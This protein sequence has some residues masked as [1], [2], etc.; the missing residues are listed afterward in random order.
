MKRIPLSASQN[1]FWFYEQLYPNTAAN[2]LT[3]AC[4]LRNIDLTRFQKAVHDLRNRH[5]A[6]NCTLEAFNEQ[7]YLIPLPSPN[8]LS[9]DGR[10]LSIF[11]CSGLLEIPP[12]KDL[13]KTL[14]SIEQDQFITQGFSFGQGPLWRCA[15][16][17]FSENLFQFVMVV[18]HII[19]D[20]FSENILMRDL[21][22]LY[23]NEQADLPVLPALNTFDQLSQNLAPQ[24]KLDFWQKTLKDLTPLTLKTDFKPQTEFRHRGE[25]FYFEVS[26][27]LVQALSD[28]AT[29]QQSSLHRTF[30][31]SL[32]AL[33]YRYTGQTDLCIGTTSANRR[34]YIKNVDNVVSC[35]MNSIPLRLL[36]E[37]GKLSFTDLLQ[38]LNSI[39]IE[40][41]QNQL[42]FDVI[43]KQAMNKRDK[44]KTITAS[45]FDII[46]SLNKK[47]TSLTLQDAEASYP[48]ELTLG[49]SRFPLGLN[50]DEMPDGSYRAYLEYNPDFFKKSTIER[51]AGHLQNTWEAV[52]AGPQQILDDLSFLT[53]EER[54]LLTQ[55]HDTLQDDPPSDE[56]SVAQLFDRVVKENGQKPAVVFHLSATESESFTYTELDEKAKMLAAL[57]QAAGVGPEEVV[58][59]SLERSA[60]LITALW[61]VFKAS[62]VMLPLETESSELLA[63]KIDQ[64]CPKVILVDNTTQSLTAFKNYPGETCFINLDDWAEIE[65]QFKNLDLPLLSEEVK[66]EDL[67]YITYTSGSTGKP[68]GVMTTHR[69]LSNAAFAIQ[70]R[71]L[72]KGSK[73]LCTAQ[74]SFDCFFFEVLEALM[75]QGELHLIFEKGRLDPSVLQNIISLHGINVVTLL[76]QISNYLDFSILPS[77]NDIIIMGAIANEETLKRLEVLSR[78]RQASDGPLTVRIE[79]G[80][81][82]ATIFSTEH[83]YQFVLPH[84]AIGKPIRNTQLFILDKNEHECPIGIPGEIYI[85]GPSLA[86]GYFNNPKLTEEKFLQRLYLADQHQFL[87]LE[88]EQKEDIAEDR[89]MRLYRT[90]DSACRSEDGSINFIGR[91][92]G[93]KQVKIHGVRVELDSIETILQQHPDIKDCVVAFD[94]G[95]ETLKGYFVLK[96]TGQS[97]NK[98]D[99]NQFLRK[100]PLPQV[101]RLSSI[102]FVEKLPVNSNGKVDLTALENSAD[103]EALFDL[104]RKTEDIA[105]NNLQRQL[106]PIWE[107]ILDTNIDSIEESFDELGGDSLNL[108][109]MT[110]QLNEKLK[111]QLLR[112]V[113]VTDLC[114]HMTIRSLA[115]SLQPL[116]L[117]KRVIRTSSSFFKALNDD[118]QAIPGAFPGSPPPAPN[119][120][121]SPQEQLLESSRNFLENL[122]SQKNSP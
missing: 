6:L 72:K 122:G 28:L 113:E 36:L 94:P 11:D 64:S 77:L 70:D 61:S 50:L 99:L 9:L 103:Q 42:P 43:A 114:F 121:H 81:Q 7:S 12:V 29:S 59:V 23:N 87:P 105:E 25:R 67:A 108:I 63:Y 41:Y 40:A 1:S 91:I 84:T 2:H 30:L 78:E 38:K 120:P 4:E 18:H 90:G 3:I 52:A 54:I 118:P 31:A 106:I 115:E 100:Y 20:V 85:A 17:R 102:F 92:E 104:E 101:A 48:T 44:R 8:E 82:E 60:K 93:N 37:D 95:R 107:K 27:L 22:M 75:T 65:A 62:G 24:K 51:M 53:K 80:V 58:G 49:Y 39:C 16:L 10:P 117:T 119:Y 32:Y 111:A 13:M 79:Y 69:G 45:P 73:V 14:K 97:P 35:F 34:D 83:P 96:N 74:P 15:V 98:I 76:P 5:D 89:I 57:L 46:F 112:P 88:L 66:P 110:T 109:A 47:R 19:A 68:K 56:T 26:P 116:L 71:G 33:L 55:S 21:S 86:R